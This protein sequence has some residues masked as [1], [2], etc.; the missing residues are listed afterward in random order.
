MKETNENNEEENLIKEE[1]NQELNKIN[2]NQEKDDKEKLKEIRHS[3]YYNIKDYLFF[4]S[5]MICSSMNFSY[6][7]I[8]FIIL[9]F[10]LQF[11][12]GNN[13]INSK[14]IKYFFE[15]AS[16]IYS[17]LLIIIKI[18]FLSLVNNDN[19]FISKNSAIFL[20]IGICYLRKNNTS[21]YFI[22]TFLGELLVLLFSFYSIIISRK[23]KYFSIEND[24][25][26]MKNNF[27]T[28]GNLIILNYIFILSFAVFNVSFLTLFYMSIL[29][30]LF[31]LNSI[32][33]NQIIL[34]KL[35]RTIFKILR[36]LI[37]IQIGFINLFN[38]P[39]L[40]ENILHKEDIKDKYGNL[41]VYSIYTQIG[42]NY[43][44]NDK[45]SYVLKEWIGYLAGVLSLI[46]LTFSLNN[47]RL[48][49][50][51]LV[52]NSS[53]MSF[54]KARSLLI[55]EDEI[56][57]KKN[58]GKK[59]AKIKRIKRKV[60]KGINTVKNKLEIIIKFIISPICIIQFCRVISIFYIYFYP[61]YYSIGIYIP[62]CFS[63]IYVDVNKNKKL[64][65]YLLT[66]TV[67]IIS[68][69]YQ[70][71]NINGLFENYSP[72]RKRKYLNLALGKYEY[73]FLEYYGH[74]LF[75]IFIMFLISSFYGPY[76]KNNIINNNFNIEMD[77]SIINDDM[78]KPLLRNTIDNDIIQEMEEPSII[79]INEKEIN[80][81]TITNLLLKI[82]FTHIDK[83]TLIAMYFV[84]MGSIN[85]IHLFLV[86]IFI[87]QILFPN[88]IK[89]MY[90]AIL[91][92]LQILF[93]I[94][95]YIHIF[96]AYFFESFNNS[97]DLMNIFLIY[98]EN[99]TDNNME[100]SIYLVLYCFYF[101]YQFDNFPYLKN[102]MNNKII[103]I[104]NYIEKKMNK[105]PTTKYILNILCIIISNLYIWFLIAIFFIVICYFEINLLFAIKLGYFLFLSYNIIKKKHNQ[106]Y[107]L[108]KDLNNQGIIL[109]DNKFSPTIHYIFLI[110]CMLNSFLVYLYQF[111]NNPLINSKFSGISSDNFFIKNLPNIGFSI[112]QKQNLYF[113]FLPHFGITFISVLFISEIIRQIKLLKP[114]ILK[115]SKTIAILNSK[116]E[117]IEKK[118]NNDSLNEEDKE[119][120]KSDIYRENVRVL[121]HLKFKYFL[122]NLIKI[123]AEFYWLF[124]FLS[125]GIIFSFYDLSFSM[126]IYIIIFAIFFILVFMRRIIKLTKYINEKPTYFI[127]K[128]IRYE[129]VERPLSESQN[130]YYR[131]IAFKILLSYNFIFLIFMYLFAVFDLFQH[132]CNDQFFKG[133]E[134]SNKP[135]FEPDGNI[136]NYIKAYGYL[137]GLYIDIR[138]E[139]L[140]EVAWVHIL[141]SLLIGFDVYSQRLLI[142]YT[143]EGKHIRDN[144]LK[145]TNENN[146][147]F[148]YDD[149]R[150]QIIKIKIGL[151]LAGIP[152]SKVAIKN[153]EEA[154][155][156]LQKEIEKNKKQK[157]ETEE[158]V[159]K[160]EK[161]TIDK[162]QNKNGINTKSDDKIIINEKNNIIELNNKN[163]EDEK[164]MQVNTDENLNENKFLRQDMIKKFLKIFSDSN[165]NN[166]TLNKSN[167]NGTKLIW[168]LKKIFEELII[169][170]LICIAL[171]KLNMLSLLY[172]IYFV[173]LTITK[174]TIIKFYILYCVLLILTI[175]QSIIYVTNL[176]E[177]TSPRPNSN[178]LNIL[179]NELSI[180]WYKNK[181]NIEKKYAFFYGFGVNKTQMGLLLLEYLII[182][183]LYI[184]LH[185]FSFSIYQDVK[186]RGEI[187]LTKTK[188]NFETV[189]LN[190][191]DKLYIKEMDKNLFKQYEECLYNFDVDIGS[192]S[193][194]NM[195]EI[196]EDPEVELKMKYRNHTYEY[197]IYKKV[198]ILKLCEIMK[199]NGDYSIPDPDY[200]KVLQEFIYIY[201]H[202]FF[203]FF[204]IIISIMIPGLISIFYL[205]I[206]FYYL[207]NS[208]K[209]YIGVKYGYPKQIKKL[210]RICLIID[211]IIQ[212]IYQIPYISSDEN[213]IFHKIFTALGFSKLLNYLD[214]SDIE[215][216]STSL[217][218]IIGKPLIYLIIS[219][220]TIIYNSNDF[221]RYYLV[222]LFDVEYQTK[223]NSLVNAYIFNNSRIQEFKKSIELRI[224]NET[225]MEKIKDI[226]EIWTKSFR[227]E[228]NKIFEGPR[229][230][231]LKYL[232]EERE[233]EEEE[234]KKSDEKKSEED[235]KIE[236]KIDINIEDIKSKGVISV[237]EINQKRNRKIVDPD[238]IK[239]KLT[240]IL[241]NGKIM[242]FYLWFNRN[243][244]FFKEMNSH[245]KLNFELESFIGTIITRSYIENQIVD[246][247]K[248]LDLTDFDENEVEILEDF[249]IKFTK[250]KL[251]KELNIIKNEIM[252]EK[253]KI[254]NK[255][256]NEN[257]YDEIITKIDE[258]NEEDIINNK[259][260]KKEVEYNIKK[261]EIKIN[262]NTNKF[263][264]FYYV[265]DSQLFKYE[266]NNRFLI[267]KIFSQLISFLENN[268]DYLIYIIMIINHCYNC[269][270]LSMFYPISVFCFALL[271]NPRPKKTYWQ[272]CF[273]Y[274]L[275]LLSLKFIIQ[276]KIFNSIMDKKQYSDII[277]KLYNYKIG[278][279]YFDEGF[280]S[281]FFKY[282]F[283]D[284]FILLLLSLNKNI[285]ISSGLWE[286]R[287][288]QI[289]NIFLAS[290]RFEIFKDLPS[291]EEDD[292]QHIYE[293]SRYYYSSYIFDYI[294]KYKRNNNYNETNENNSL[295]EDMKS[296]F[297]YHKL[298]NISKYDDGDKKYFQKLFPK[299]RNEKPGIDN[300]P[301]LSIS[302]TIIIIYILLF[303]TQMAQDKTYGPVNLNTTQFSGNMVLFLI[304]H[305]AMLVYDRII[306]LSQNK[307]GLKY[308]YFIYKINK[309]YIGIFIS[310]EEYN[311]IKSGYWL[312]KE[313]PYHFSPNVIKSL[314]DNGY[315]IM[316]IQTEQFNKPLLQKYILHIFSTFICHFF[317]FFYFPMTGNNNL[318]NTVYCN[319]QDSNLCND[320]TNNA[321]IIIFYILYI[322]YLYFSSVQIRLGYYDIRRK[323]LFKRNTN[324]TNYM[325]K[326]FNA[327]P[328]LP[329]I[330]NIIDWTFTSTC[331][332]LFQW[333]KFE[334]IYDSIFDAFTEEDENDDLPVG[335]KY[336]RKKKL[337]I[338]G[339]LSFILIFIIILPLI[340]FSS[341]NPTNKLNNLTKGK[342]NI[343]LSFVY[344]N[345]IELNYNLFE[346]ERAKTIS[347][348]F[349]NGDTDW[350]KNKY[351]KSV[352]TMNFNHKQIQI[353]K[354]SETS[355]RNWDLA[356]PH[357][358][359]LIELLNITNNKG[360]ESIKLVIKLE[361][362]RD[363]PAET[364]TVTHDFDI[365]IFNKSIDDPYSSKG[366]IKIY[367]LRNALANCSDISITFE[368]GYSSPLRFT[369]GEDVTEI[370]D[371]NYIIKKNIQLGFQGCR[372]QLLMLNNELKEEN[373]YLKSYFTFSSKYPEENDYSGAEFHAFND[374][375][376]ETISGY[377]VLTFYL[378]F[379]LVIGTY[380]AD[381]L[382]SEPSKI[383]F[384]DLPHPKQ[385]VEL[386]EG[387]KIARYSY[388]FKE[389]EHL[390]SI[391]IELMRTP[392]YLKK[393]TDSSLEN[394]ESRKQKINKNI[395]DDDKEEPKDKK[396][397]G[398][399][400]K[401]SDD[402]DDSE[403]EEEKKEEQNVEDQKEED[404]KEEEEK[405]EEKVKESSNNP[406]NLEEEKDK[407]KTENN[408]DIKNDKDS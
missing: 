26:L 209:I 329:Q 74:N 157:K 198:E 191:F 252:N 158:K 338:G 6:L 59:L 378:T 140:I 83:I 21:F 20:D 136:E 334:S 278:T 246:T 368:K 33:I 55:E 331:F 1:D 174:K 292:Q 330:R 310:K 376:S 270:I 404:K 195:L 15:L 94:E 290:E 103:N 31:L 40:Q 305:I 395:K 249:F 180:P 128:V 240:N 336:E 36:I 153:M 109:N 89:K 167:N 126:T 354:F 152:N 377:S 315:N 179:N 387:I 43:T 327:I 177:D 326:I 397:E 250:G 149:F 187:E 44:Y 161:Q 211:I 4:F 190:T 143:L 311:N 271:E 22:M 306:Y 314:K 165:D 232:K 14:S 117:E 332:D 405:E 137:F 347:D 335:K 390:Y 134:R 359:D 317:A 19:S 274:T 237:F 2:L 27:W 379:I 201:L 124:L 247:L 133:C 76:K 236:E 188:F 93:L 118:L 299:I 182:I 92:I 8:P 304:L 199:K 64:T 216:A 400:K 58:S 407:K 145:I 251:Q 242:K 111:K 56:D 364:Q 259:S 100:L 273:Y 356:E 339:T 321:F 206:C 52:K 300:Y 382:A 37:L 151:K 98:T 70:L 119:I 393:L 164:I 213:D 10:I 172:F 298:K 265:L 171:T 90:K 262:I 73:S 13:S 374:V 350:V 381:Y 84:S 312:D 107:C 230:E 29:Q 238:K 366:A 380:V 394:Y 104:D 297:H 399:D 322:V 383:M 308:K 406:N 65:L 166:Q 309:L 333:I 79:D 96:K 24:T 254:I 141:L 200:V 163:E 66:P 77:L 3:Y 324:I 99:I 105:L 121:K 365:E 217:I 106:E 210:L 115:Q 403:Y 212:L 219:L 218:E 363:L 7:Y 146:T 86:V 288:E 295:I 129:F 245:G 18:I 168:F 125:I 61:N 102:I 45:I 132:G 220:Q 156:K 57:D 135:I 75:Y 186:N 268:F 160:Q 319:E 375:I 226:V 272:I 112:Y 82:I 345:D 215:L 323:S 81:L 46:I 183:S 293:T 207:I 155:I 32:K 303:F 208:H 337:G 60:S 159:E 224:N 257:K 67:F 17:I 284:A 283:L 392:D 239:E 175:I 255:E 144:I 269:S 353:I 41:K 110:F 28:S 148:I 95:L 204:I 385:I 277:K 68:F 386:C 261:G 344:A 231:P 281:D 69:F 264:Q 318:L 260:E 123:C 30:I 203:L 371:N 189:K 169:I 162:I 38:I 49:E 108:N 286:K 328:F 244:I 289:E 197:L 266:L 130:K 205:V 80:D 87:I 235:K 296:I 357:I 349:K 138:N 192:Q 398:K 391:L 267:K 372:K 229:K 228:K 384:T 401:D 342:L 302:L 193:F 225:N 154:Y 243:S 373:T 263:K 62:L 97:K 348:M 150:D 340:L 280:S 402:E 294:L 362:G 223:R 25:S 352:Q 122:V 227:N 279:R 370:E 142:K 91:Y 248:F 184:Y 202:I 16:M 194:E 346:N 72:I 367:E 351:D 196:K 120:L 256:E 71:S 139:G 316:Y 313:K 9:G 34:D 301:F 241:L 341:L 178:I 287:E 408:T 275:S 361:F 233:N 131:G 343:D 307:T 176:S 114:I 369:A 116:K 35:S 221:K 12:I 173:Y 276:L 396:E 47:L 185:F 51:E 325:Y 63:S 214:N 285:L 127:S 5:L 170:L 78:I 388:D 48:Y 282:I 88:K 54:L 23:C 42:I 101:Q 358:K 39:R 320:F 222:F 11:L 50:I 258:N 53:S 234:L 355:D 147:L 291:I 113:N 360:L 85:L 253:K 181:L 389:E